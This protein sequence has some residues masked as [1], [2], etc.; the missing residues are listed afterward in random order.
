MG[1]AGAVVGKSQSLVVSAELCHDMRWGNAALS[2][3][4][5]AWLGSVS[6]HP[7]S[8]RGQHP[9]AQGHCSLWDEPSGGSEQQHRPQPGCSP[10]LDET[11]QQS[12]CVC[13]CSLHPLYKHGAGR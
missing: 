11:E 8:W 10:S 3:N 1:Q 7:S 6:C 9:A 13:G 5:S 12:F 4:F 2:S